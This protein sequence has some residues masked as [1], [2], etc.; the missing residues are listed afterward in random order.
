MELEEM[1]AIGMNQRINLIAAEKKKVNHFNTGILD[2]AEKILN[3][4]F[5]KYQRGETD[6]LDVLMAQRT[7]NEIR[8][9]YL[10]SQRGL[11]SALIQLEKAYGL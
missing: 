4:V 5:Y 9:Q 3:G 10:E 2:D 7:F 8:E 11:A 6:I 1:I